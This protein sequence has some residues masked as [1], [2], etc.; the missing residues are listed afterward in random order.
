MYD[1]QPDLSF[2]NEDDVVKSIRSSKYCEG[3]GIS[4]DEFEIAA[5]EG[6]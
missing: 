6:Y 3:V 1:K 2:F 4:S 5:S